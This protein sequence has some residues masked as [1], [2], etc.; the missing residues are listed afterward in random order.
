M[1]P[2]PVDQETVKH[3]LDA[4]KLRSHM[5]PERLIVAQLLRLDSTDDPLG[6]GHQAVEFVIGTNIKLAEAGSCRPSGGL[7]R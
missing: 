7:H 4:G 3:R 1:A 6:V 2:W 5:L